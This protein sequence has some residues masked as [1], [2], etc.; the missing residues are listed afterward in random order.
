MVMKQSPKRINFRLALYYVQSYLPQLHWCTASSA[1]KREPRSSVVGD[2]SDDLRVHSFDRAHIASSIKTERETSAER[3][4]LYSIL[5][6]G[7]A[8]YTLQSTLTVN[9][10]VL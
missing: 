5:P 1:K 8:H 9:G 3:R 4:V 7:S 2:L 10:T 6:N